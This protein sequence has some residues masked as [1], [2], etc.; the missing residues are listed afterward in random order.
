MQITYKFSAAIYII[1]VILIYQEEQ[2]ITSQVISSSLNINPVEVRQ[3]IQD[4]KKLDIINV[5]LGKGG[6]YINKPLDQI[7]L[8]DIFKAVRYNDLSIFKVYNDPNRNCIVGKNFY[9]TISKYF[10]A[11]EE[12]LFENMKKISMD[13]IYNDLAKKLK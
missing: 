8:Y 10:N 11:I 2:K 12:G 9:S 5:N 3:I 6:Y 1:L 7:N 13:T 4:L